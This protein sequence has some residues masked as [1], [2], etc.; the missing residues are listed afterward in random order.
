[1]N[2]VIVKTVRNSQKL[3]RSSDTNTGME[4]REATMKSVENQL[5]IMLLLVTTLFFILLCPT[6]FRF[7]YL[8][9][10]KRDTPSKYAQLMLIYQITKTLQYQQWDKLFVILH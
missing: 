5:T 10:A 8:V 2:Y 6:Y 7:I 4:K 9:F 3:F 1:M